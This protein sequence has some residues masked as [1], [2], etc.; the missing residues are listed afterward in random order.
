[1]PFA[2]Q[3]PR[4]DHAG[5]RRVLE[6]RRGA[7]IVSIVTVTV[8]AMRKTDNPFFG[9]V[10][11]VVRRN[12]MCGASY[13][14]SVNRRREKEG[15]PLDDEGFVEKFTSQP[16]PWGTHDGP[17]FVRHT[18]KG[19]TE[20]KLYLKFLPNSNGEEQWRNPITKKPYDAEQL[21]AIKTFLPKRSE[22]SRQEIENQVEW[23]TIAL[24]SIEQIKIDGELYV[25]EHP[26]PMQLA[27][28]A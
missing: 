9:L 1:M 2:R 24:D 4:I 17:F 14:S 21:A 23:R 18:P 7:R 13:E 22:S 10:E 16:L 3:A 19:A 11:R 27:A 5:L 12:G 28:A 15:Q 8:P 6:A 20:E 25:I 26:Q